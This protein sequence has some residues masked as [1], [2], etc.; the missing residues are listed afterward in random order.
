MSPLRED[1]YVGGRDEGTLAVP[2]L[3]PATICLPGVREDFQDQVEAKYYANKN[4]KMSE[5]Q[6]KA[7]NQ[8]TLSLS[9]TLSLSS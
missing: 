7:G 6:T 2:P 9:H 8:I 4:K 5:C 1:I 3:G